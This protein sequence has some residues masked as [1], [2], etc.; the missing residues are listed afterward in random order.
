MITLAALLKSADNLKHYGIPAEFIACM[1]EAIGADTSVAFVMDDP[2][3]LPYR[4]LIEDNITV[5]DMADDQVIKTICRFLP[6]I[7]HLMNE[8]PVSICLPP[9]PEGDTVMISLLGA[10][11]RAAL[12]LACLVADSKSF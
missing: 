6:T 2:S 8:N 11:F 3:C 12:E 4:S 1:V 7:S 9:L 5:G 10:A